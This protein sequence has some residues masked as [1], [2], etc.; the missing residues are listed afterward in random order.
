MPAMSRYA[1]LPGPFWSG[2][3]CAAACF[4]A[5]SFVAEQLLFKQLSGVAYHR[6]SH[7]PWYN[8][9]LV[10]KDEFR[11][12]NGEIVFRKITY[13]DGTVK[14]E[15]DVSRLVWASAWTYV[16]GAVIG[17]FG[18]LYGWYVSS[19]AFRCCHRLIEPAPF[20]P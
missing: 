1:S 20:P 18:G 3:V 2:C 5:G 6:R 17:L 12:L 8:S 16:I 11:T 13:L 15:G 9:D 7:A 4:V 14:E 10:D 19:R